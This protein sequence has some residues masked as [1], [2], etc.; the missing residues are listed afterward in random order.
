[1][2]TN[3]W[4]WRGRI[5]PEPYTAWALA[6]T[7]IKLT[8]DWTIARTLFN[9]P[10]S[11]LEYITPDTWS[12]LLSYDWGTRLFYGTLLVFS[13]PFAWVGAMLTIRRLRSAALPLWLAA[14]F[15]LPVINLILFVSLCVLPEQLNPEWNHP[16][17][18]RWTPAALIPDNPYGSAAVAVFVTALLGWGLTVL[19]AEGLELYGVGLFIGLPFCLG[20]V[21]SLIHCAQA[22]R[23]LSSCL[24]VSMGSL[25]VVLGLMLVFA[26]E[27][28]IC[29]IMAAPIWVCCTAVGAAAGYAIQAPRS[30]P[31][32]RRAMLVAL[33]ASPALMGMEHVMGPA[34]P[35]RRVSTEVVIDRPPAAVWPHVVAFPPLDTPTD[36]LF[37]AGVAYP[38]R[39]R[40]EGVGVGAVR[41]CEFSTGPFVEPITRWEPPHVLAFDVTHNPSPMRELSFYDHVEPPHLHGFMVSQRGQFELGCLPDGRTR[42]IGTTWYHNRMWPQAYWTLWSDHIIHRIHGRV[43]DHIAVVTEAEGRL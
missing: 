6:L 29:L 2:R 26:L 1:M 3:L 24:A 27:G 4:S 5:G 7:T 31:G 15:F 22:P 8:M 10:W 18:R 39:A 20:I 35:L 30:R 42:L 43:L 37:R 38:M 14:V 13:L 19:G 25:A 32:W 12:A 9:R 23:S 28:V 11:P 17:P 40:I 21:A 16:Q 41:Y 36:W 33:L 34:A